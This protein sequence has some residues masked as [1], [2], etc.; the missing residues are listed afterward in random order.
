[1]SGAEAEQSLHA[2]AWIGGVIN[3][4]DYCLKNPGW[5]QAHVGTQIRVTWRDGDGSE[6]CMVTRRCKLTKALEWDEYLSARMPPEFR[7]HEGQG[8]SPVHVSAALE[9]IGRNK[10]VETLATL[11]VSHVDVTTPWLGNCAMQE[12]LQQHTATMPF[13]GSASARPLMLT[14]SVTLV[15]VA[16]HRQSTEAV[17]FHIVSH[18]ETASELRIADANSLSD[19]FV[20]LRTEQGKA[21]TSVKKRT[22]E[23]EWNEKLENRMCAGVRR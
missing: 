2:I 22:L 20:V 17:M 6:V 10:T 5:D 14:L 7:A 11:T 4:E 13:D 8:D 3:W 16:R 9:R 15:K 19:P 12:I 1:M 21:K 18:V 23:P